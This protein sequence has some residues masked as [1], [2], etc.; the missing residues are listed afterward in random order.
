MTNN[1]QTVFFEIKRIGLASFGLMAAAPDFLHQFAAAQT[2]ARLRQEKGAG[3]RSSSAERSTALNVVVPHGEGEYYNLRPTIAIPKPG[4]TDGAIDLDG[5]LDFIRRLAPL[6]PLWKSKQLAHHRRGRLAR[7]YA[8]AF[9]RPGLYGIR[10]AG[11]QRHQRRL[12]QPRPAERQAKG[13]FA[14]PSC[15]DDAAVAAFAL[16]ASTVVAMTNLADFSIKA[17]IYTQNMKGGFEAAWQRTQRMSRRNRQR[18]V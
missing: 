10:H 7:Q 2:A 13:R 15:C 16:W 12:A 5:I 18:N 11:Q 14:V 6:E 8:F 1:G 17:G 9:R 4:K 3:H